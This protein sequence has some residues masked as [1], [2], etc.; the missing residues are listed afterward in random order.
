MR[1]LAYES[2]P[3]NIHQVNLGE[4]TNCP[5][6][7]WINLTSQLETI[8]VCQ[9]SVGRCDSKDDTSRSRYVLQ[10]HVFDLLFDVFG[11]VSDRHLC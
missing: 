3:N 5:S 1:F 8:R 4:N 10:K 6:P 11:L 9:V 7:L 2:E